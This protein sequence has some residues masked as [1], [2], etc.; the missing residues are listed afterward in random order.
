MRVKTWTNIL[1]QRLAQEIQGARWE[2]DHALPL[3]LAF[4]Q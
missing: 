2:V 3:F 4:Q 1:R